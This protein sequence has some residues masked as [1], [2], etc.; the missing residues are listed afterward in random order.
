MDRIVA[1]NITKTFQLKPGQSVEVDGVRTEAI[2]VLAGLDL[3]IRKGEFI[4]LVGP[5]GSGKSVLLDIIAGLTE[6]TSGAA[7]F[8]GQVITRPDQRMAYV[9]QQYALF[10]WRTA[11][12]NVEYALEVRGVG[13][14]PRRRIA[15]DFLNL[16]RPRRVRGPLPRAALGRHAAARRDR[17]VAYRRSRGAADGRALRGTRRADPRHPADRASAH[18]GADQHARWC[19]SPIR[20]TRRSISPTGWSR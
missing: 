7:R 18:L 3:T 13:A 5:S 20:S 6:A 16:L 12:E 19:S 1:T 4:T 9:F 8:D 2:T 14:R 11:L 10:P 17:A 15:R